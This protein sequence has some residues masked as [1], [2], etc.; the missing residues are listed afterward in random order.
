MDLYEAVEKRR[1]VRGY[2]DRP[3]EPDKLQRV[4]NAARIAPSAR[5]AQ[6]WKF[7]VVQDPS[8]RHELADQAEQPLLAKAPVVIAAV[9]T[10]PERVMRC[11]VESGPVDCAIAVD[12][13]TLAAVAEGLGTCWIGSFDQEAC[14]RLMEVPPTAKIIELMVLGYPADQPGPKSRKAMQDVVCYERFS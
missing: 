10:N 13:M 2:Q 1:S 6:D 9:S 3:V 7:V 8:V 14:C 5:N 4:L 12:H 11:G